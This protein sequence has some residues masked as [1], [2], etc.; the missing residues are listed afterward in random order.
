MRTLADICSV[1]IS[2]ARLWGGVVWRLRRL[3]WRLRDGFLPGLARF[4]KARTAVGTRFNGFRSGVATFLSGDRESELSQFPKS[5]FWAWVRL[6]RGAWTHART[7]ETPRSAHF[8]LLA[9]FIKT[10]GRA[11]DLMSKAVG[12]MHPPYRLPQAKGVLGDLGPQQ[13]AAIQTQL[14][15][16]GYC[17]FENCLSSEFC[18]SVIQKTLQLD[19]AVVDD[20]VIGRGVPVYSRYPRGSADAAAYVMSRDDTTDIEEVQQLISDP[21]LIAVAQ[22]YLKSRP[23]FSAVAM[24]WSAATKDKPDAQAAQEFHWDMERIKW[25]RY[26]IY[27][28]D[29]TPESGPHCF[30][31]GTHRTG[32]IPQNLLK[33]GYV[34]HGDDVILNLYGKDAY[35]EFTGLRGTIVAED[36]RGFH[37]GKHPTNGDRLM[38][39]FEMSNTTFGSNKRHTI[40]NIRVPQ[41]ADYARDYPRVYS[42]FDFSPS[43]KLSS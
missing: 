12:L 19:C 31:K 3:R 24:S 8:A 16:D 10:G 35:R 22:N 32:A 28:T 13:L 43:A 1:L 5:Y 30:I 23:I 2:P 37:K 18:E 7:G 17:V 33:Q 21:S 27:L 6:L 40:R 39:A 25:L 36:S 20:E 34:R 14:E 4:H 11:N 15:I 42:N 9:L 41:L 38:L 26:F 29:V